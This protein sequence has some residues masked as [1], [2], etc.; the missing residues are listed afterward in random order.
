MLKKAD[1][2]KLKQVDH[3]ISEMMILTDI[4]NPFLVSLSLFCVSDISLRSEWMGSLKTQ[5]TCISF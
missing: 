5:D 1:I 2:I 4:K 3:V